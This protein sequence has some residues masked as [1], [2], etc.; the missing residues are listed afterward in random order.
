[1]QRLLTILTVAVGFVAAPA[2]AQQA[3]PPGRPVEAPGTTVRL[4]EMPPDPAGISGKTS[5]GRPVEPSAIS[6]KTPDERPTDPAGIAGKA[7]DAGLAAPAAM[8]NTTSD[9]RPLEP[10]AIKGGDKAPAPVGGAE[11]K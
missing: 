8:T 9:G 5:D 2:L 7:A 10:D 3:G 4:P 11:K 1:M 6:N